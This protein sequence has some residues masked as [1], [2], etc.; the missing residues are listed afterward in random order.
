MVVVTTQVIDTAR[1]MPADGLHVALEHR[2]AQGWAH[3]SGGTTD[4]AGQVE[5]L[6]PAGRELGEGVYRLTFDTGTY[7]AANEL[8]GIYPVV[9]VVFEVRGE[10]TRYHLP[11][12]LGLTGYSTFR[13]A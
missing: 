4:D 10:D 2:G 5:D 11:L 1:G 6:V 12:I 3:V 9:R 13:G 8:D 7:F